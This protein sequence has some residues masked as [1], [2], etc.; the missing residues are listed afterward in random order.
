MDLQFLVAEESPDLARVRSIA[1]R[2]FM[3]RRRH[4]WPP[5]VVA[6]PNWDTI[7]AKESDGL[8]VLATVGEA[9]TWANGLIASIEAAGAANDESGA[10]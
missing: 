6:H 10:V 9:V 4:S 3:S 2:L 7:Y 8:E 5:T 1:R